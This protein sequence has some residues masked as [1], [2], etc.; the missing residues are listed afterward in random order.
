[1]K[2]NFLRISAFI[3]VLGM[4][5]TSAY[6]WSTKNDD[7]FKDEDS[8]VTTSRSAS[9]LF[10][11][12]FS[13]TV[14][15]SVPQGYSVSANGCIVTVEPG[16]VGNSVQKNTLLL[17]DNRDGGST[18]FI[19]PKVVRNFEKQTSPFALEY[20]FKLEK[21]TTDIAPLNV[22]VCQDNAVMCTIM[23]SSGDGILRVGDEAPFGNTPFPADEWFTVRLVADLK[24]RK[25]D[26]RLQS[27]YLKGDVKNLN[28]K[29]EH[30]KKN[31]TLTMSNI[32]ILEDFNGDGINNVAFS[33]GRWAGKQHFDY[34]KVE[35][36]A[37]RMVANVKE[38]VIEAP[39]VKSPEAVPSGRYLNILFDG[40]YHFWSNKPY[41]IGGV[42]MVP[43]ANYA[44]LLGIK[45]TN[46]NEKIT[47]EQNG[48][49]L[50]LKAVT[51]TD[52]AS[53]DR[54][55]EKLGEVYVPIRYVSE[56]CGYKV[57][58]NGET[59]TITVDKEVE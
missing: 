23:I 15:G 52:Y 14:A 47:L 31:G 32:F 3:C 6:A 12:D 41:A 40:D 43:L 33:M 22:Q 35:K 48:K 30:N 54:A 50:T 7:L 39:I 42:T 45:Y 1:M 18:E 29:A 13:N 56:T 27:D 53:G 5:A 49:V 37:K 46:E 26:V 8:E 19:G 51:N 2:K 59:A 20:R 28:P 9:D 21:T 11:D 16:D 24:E 25:V 4:F 38:F 57:G 34:I 10:Y 58:W 44:K 55:V 17:H 36:D